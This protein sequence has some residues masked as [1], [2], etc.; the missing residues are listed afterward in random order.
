[1]PLVL[2]QGDLDDI[3]ALDVKSL[4]RGEKAGLTKLAS[5]YR[6][7]ELLVMEA[8]LLKFNDGNQ[9]QVRLTPVGIYG[10]PRMATASFNVAGTG[11]PGQLMDEA[12]SESLERMNQPLFLRR[13]V[14]G[15]LRTESKAIAK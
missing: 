7:S 6:A 14:E 15:K 4:A 10:T 12:V 11:H 1:P 5:R 13:S 8:T 9:L 2:P 3:S